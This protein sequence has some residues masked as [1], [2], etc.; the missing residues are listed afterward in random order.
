MKNNTELLARVER[1]LVRSESTSIR[2]SDKELH[3]DVSLLFENGIFFK[4]GKSKQT[5]LGQFC[6]TVKE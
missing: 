6:A 2:N 5:S 4:G 3:E 1:E